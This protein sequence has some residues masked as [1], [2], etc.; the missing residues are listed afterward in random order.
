MEHVVKGW[1][2]KYDWD[3]PSGIPELDR[4]MEACTSDDG[5]L[6]PHCEHKHDVWGEE[7]SNAEYMRLLH[8][9]HDEPLEATCTS[10]DKDF[11]IR[12]RMVLK[13]ETCADK[14]FGDE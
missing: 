10:C 6:C 1:R 4:Y 7:L 3:K 2:T 9:S 5:W 13:Y 14:E 12:A 8:D 11:F